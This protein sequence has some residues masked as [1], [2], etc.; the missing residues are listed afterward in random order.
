MTRNDGVKDGNTFRIR[1]SNTT[2]PGAVDIG[3]VTRFTIATG[4]DARVDTSGVAVPEVDVDL[5]DRLASVDID[6]LDING[7]GHTE[8]RLRHISAD[9]LALHVVWSLGDFGN[10]DAGTVAEEVFFGD[11]HVDAGVI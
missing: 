11:V 2:E 6:D 8:L 1:L 10:E 7:H 3:L 5:R 4:H 9:E